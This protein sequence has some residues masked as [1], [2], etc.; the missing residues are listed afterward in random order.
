MMLCTILCSHWETST[1]AGLLLNSCSDSS[2]FVYVHIG[3]IFTY[4]AL[5]STKIFTF[6][7]IYKWYALLNVHIAIFP[8]LL[9]LQN[10]YQ[11]VLFFFFL[12]IFSFFS[13]HDFSIKKMIHS[14]SNWYNCIF[15][16][17]VKCNF[18]SLNFQVVF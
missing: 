13:I 17:Y 6:V 16:F 5:I 3:D 15:I 9:F 1:L 2:S 10:F 4:S 12:F 8:N 11:I 18:L 7:H 14:Q